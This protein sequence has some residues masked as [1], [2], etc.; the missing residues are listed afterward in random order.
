MRLKTYRGRTIKEAIAK[1]RN[2][3]G[4]EALIVSTT[5]VNGNGRK[6][7]F[8]VAAMQGRDDT[9]DT[10]LSPVGDIK[11][12]LM[13]IKEMIYRLN[14]SSPLTE[15]LLMSPDTLNLYVRLIRNGIDSHYARMF[16]ETACAHK[17]ES[18]ERGI[19]IRRKTIDEIKRVIEVRN[20]FDLRDKNR[21]I[22]A[23]IGTTGVGK[24][25][26][27]AKLAARLVLTGRL[28][29]GLI[30]IDNYRI[31][32]MA[33]LKTYA[34]IIGIPCFPAFNRRDLLLAL[35]RLEARDVVLID[36]AG[37][38]HYDTHRMRELRDMIAGGDPPISAH[39]LMSVST[40]SSEMLKAATNFR[41][42]AFQSYIFTKM[43]EAQ[44]CGSIINQVLQHRAPISF[45]TT[46]QNVPEDIEK[47][48]KERIAARLL[49]NN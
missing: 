39:L 28:K 41:P 43:D 16:L 3:L 10:H 2:S 46:G 14:H 38:S 13:S 48:N 42:L 11:S 24:T 35:G 29:V 30:M 4:P 18:S 49:N 34:D 33:Q 17:A 9:N 22:A 6:T 23:F 45:I 15:A 37:L 19:D 20:P 8:E 40:R 44:Q 27:I 25:T 12:E 26:T 31:G 21:K 32:A 7:G 47:A 5:P 36:T 1:V